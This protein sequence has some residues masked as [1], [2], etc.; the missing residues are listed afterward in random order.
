MNVGYVIVEIE[1]KFKNVLKFY[2][3]E[4]SS[5]YKMRFNKMRYCKEIK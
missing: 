3:V 4:G 5:V 1:R 2:L